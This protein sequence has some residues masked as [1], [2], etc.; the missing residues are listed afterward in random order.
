QWLRSYSHDC[1]KLVLDVY[2]WGFDRRLNDVLGSLVPDLALVQLGDGRLPPDK[3]QSRC[4]LGAG[5]I[6]LAEYLEQLTALGY[7]GYY[8]LEL[9]GEEIESLDYEPL[10][11]QCTEV[12][13]QWMAT[14]TS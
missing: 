5:E 6:P 3:E 4:P 9:M 10:L 8:E 1:L 12:Y 7:D 14:P 2:Q 11:R 13:Q